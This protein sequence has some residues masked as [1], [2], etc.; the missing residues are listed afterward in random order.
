MTLAL[1]LHL[2]IKW[3]IKKTIFS[4]FCGGEDIPECKSTIAEL[5]KN[6]VGTILDYS[7]EGK[8]TNADLDATTQ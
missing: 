6:K 5:N 1:K 2:P 8:E 4:Q 3:L 7:L